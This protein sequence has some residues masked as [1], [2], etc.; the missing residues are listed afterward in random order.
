LGR[1]RIILVSKRVKEARL[2]KAVK[3]FIKVIFGPVVN[4]LVASGV[5]L[6]RRNPY[7]SM[8]LVNNLISRGKEWGFLSQIPSDFFYRKK[9][10]K[11]KV[12]WKR[13]MLEPLL[14]SENSD[15]KPRVKIFVS[16]SSDWDSITN[17]LQSFRKVNE[18]PNY[19][20]VVLS[21]DDD[22]RFLVPLSSKT[23]NLNVAF[24]TPQQMPLTPGGLLN[25]SLEIDGDLF[26]FLDVNGSPKDDFLTSIVESFRCQDV[27]IVGGRVWS[28]KF[29]FS[30]K[31]FSA[32]G[33]TFDWE[34][35]LGLFKP[36]AIFDAG[37]LAPKDSLLQT[38][39][40]NTG[41]LAIRRED[42]VSLGGFDA[43]LESGYLEQELCLRLLRDLG[44]KVVVNTEVNIY[45]DA[46]RRS[47]EDGGDTSWP[48]TVRNLT[49]LDETVG[50]FIEGEF[51][52]NRFSTGLSKL[53][54]VP[55]IGFFTT[56]TPADDLGHGD[57]LVAAS[58]GK[59]LSREFGWDYTLV[60]TR[61]WHSDWTSLDA[62]VTMRPDC[63]VS[64][65]AISSR[66]LKMAWMRNGL[67]N[68]V[69]TL[70]TQ[71][72]DLTFVSSEAGKKYMDRKTRHDSV[73]LRIALDIDYVGTEEPSAIRSI[74]VLV[75]SSFWGLPRNIHS[76][77]PQRKVLDL[78]VYGKGWDSSLSPSF[79]RQKWFGYLPYKELSSLYSQTRVVVDDSTGYAKPWGLLN[80]RVFEAIGGGSLVLTNDK[81]GISELFGS[82]APTWEEADD[83]SHLVDRYLSDENERNSLALAMREVILSEHTYKIRAQEFRSALF[84]R[85]CSSKLH[86]AGR[87]NSGI[88]QQG[89]HSSIR[90]NQVAFDTQDVVDPGIDLSALPSVTVII[91]VHNTASHLKEAVDS[92]LD[93]VGVDVK[94]IIVDDASTDGSAE[95]AREI[96][97]SDSR[98]TSILNQK[99]MG[100]Y[101]CR[102][103]GMLNSKT[104]FLAFLDSDDIQNQ[105]RLITQ[106][107]P[108]I[109]DPFL[110]ATYC[111]ARRWEDNF[112]RPIRTVGLG[113]ISVVFRKELI[114]QIGFFDSV[115]FAGDAEFRARLIEWFSRYAIKDLADELYKL[116][117]RSDSL[118]SSGVGAIL[119]RGNEGMLVFSNSHARDTYQANFTAWHQSGER[120]YIAFP[121][122]ERLFAAGHPDQS[123]GAD[124]S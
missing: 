73:V 56:S 2:K 108:L 78:R 105:D 53:D 14:E 1:G 49:L 81:L 58:L 10:P 119:S 42:F 109:E 97:N 36:V 27:G 8:I 46:A 114:D 3:R 37:R 38:W 43:R 95:I 113:F 69:D 66:A 75:T 11:G 104:E 89:P 79:L 124:L 103:I 123:I 33:M 31:F 60:P 4:L 85:I 61:D 34:P 19:E 22:S 23:Q 87:M 96:S 88:I 65:L 45:R 70:H 76:W 9:I 28:R 26:V 118:T 74:D 82:L 115:R 100:A 35:R 63:A 16:P 44:K 92:A 17:F 120:L 30:R 117:F 83:I 93:S 54:F 84:E 90:S 116:R 86:I 55:S 25:T 57:P 6:I 12:N 13:A 47:T 94:V 7:L 99:N 77:K 41:L 72:F 110:R 5:H 67:N 111:S 51:L 62:V 122:T 39:A 29:R 24:A 50:E 40:V 107:R 71:D 64:E 52:V 20:I 101:F 80:M 18:Y 102:N 48:A 91:A 112:T 106:I 15:F 121:L 98:V 68:W 32:V 21:S 59:F